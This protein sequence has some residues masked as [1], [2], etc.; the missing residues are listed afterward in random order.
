MFI[1]VHKWYQV[2]QLWM[3]ELGLVG[4]PEP[5]EENHL[6][7]EIIIIYYAESYSST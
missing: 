6:H 1:F 4:K 3:Y 7:K 5:P 2:V